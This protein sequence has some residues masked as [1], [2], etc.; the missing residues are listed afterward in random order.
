MLPKHVIEVLTKEEAVK[1][2][3]NSLEKSSQGTIDFND[4]QI[5]LESNLPLNMSL[6]LRNI[7][8]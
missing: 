5:S 7:K 6:H 4:Y 3:Q 1:L 2:V 8:K